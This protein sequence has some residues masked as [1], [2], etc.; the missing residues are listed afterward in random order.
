MNFMVKKALVP[1]VLV[2]LMF[3][4]NQTSRDAD[5]SDIHVNINIMRFDKEL[6]DADP[7]RIEELIPELRKKYG[8]FFQIF[9][10]RIIG[11]GSDQNPSYPAYLTE[12]VTDYLNYQIYRRTLEVFPDTGFIMSELEDAFKHY[13]YY[14]P[15]MQ[16]PEVVT[17]VSGINLSVVSDSGL[18]GIG[19]DDYLGVDEPVYKQLGIYQYLV[20]GMYKERIAADCMRLWAMTEFPY[21][22]SINNLVCNMIYEGSVMYFVDKMIPDKPDTLKWGFTSKEMNFCRE[23]EQQMWAYLVE[24]KLLFNSDKFTIDKFT[25]EGPFTKDFSEESP[26]RAAVWIGYR[27][28]NDYMDHNKKPGLNDL[29]TEKDYQKILNASFYNP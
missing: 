8:R 21:N 24:N 16:I 19:L 9:N 1:A 22:D 6:F 11:I 27:I 17:Y 26:A 14:F 2:W 20:K 3:S 29:M 5:V 15:D 23:N 12:F 13:K 18:L 10:Y 28:V 7:S 25:R 4:C